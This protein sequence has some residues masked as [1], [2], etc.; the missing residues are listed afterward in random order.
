MSN[1]SFRLF[2]YRHGRDVATALGR[3]IFGA[4]KLR[5]KLHLDGR[6]WAVL[7]EHLTN[8]VEKNFGRNVLVDV[9]VTLTESEALILVMDTG[10]EW[11]PRRIHRDKFAARHRGGGLRIIR[12]FS[13]RF[14]VWRVGNQNA[15]M[16][17]VNLPPSAAAM[18]PEVSVTTSAP[19]TFSAEMDRMK[20][21]LRDAVQLLDVR[22]G[23]LTP[24]DLAYAVYTMLRVRLKFCRMAVDI[25]IPMPPPA[26][27]LEFNKVYGRQDAKTEDAWHYTAAA[28]FMTMRFGWETKPLHPA[29]IPA[30]EQR[31]LDLIC[32]VIAKTLENYAAIYMLAH[33]L[34]TMAKSASYTIN[35]VQNFLAEKKPFILIMSDLDRFKSVND[36][37]GHAM[38]DEVLRGY[39]RLCNAAVLRSKIKGAFFGRLGGEE[40]LTVI[41]VLPPSDPSKVFDAAVALTQDYILSSREQRYTASENRTFVVTTSAGV[42]QF[43]SDSTAVFTDFDSVQKPVDDL[44]YLAKRTTCSSCRKDMD[45]RLQIAERCPHC[46]SVDI[47]H[48]RNR[49]FVLRPGNAVPVELR[50]G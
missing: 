27:A 20:I 29:V 23:S 37:Y 19:V 38:G 34:K 15:F 35:A 10:R 2:P 30:S 16:A 45:E 26:S 39:V 11:K 33:D 7:H 14:R 42:R 41:P 28:G 43:A 47:S 9:D 50:C 49:A 31:I 8:V 17:V 13:E 25:K 4:R 48:G 18:T 40:F 3:V 46:S 21:S 1:A 32:S 12:E 44:L 5:D 6:A 36:T 24:E 22:G